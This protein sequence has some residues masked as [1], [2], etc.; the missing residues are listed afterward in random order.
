VDSDVALHGHNASSSTLTYDDNQIAP[1]TSF[2]VRFRSHCLSFLSES[3][4][5]RLVT[6][7]FRD[8][9]E[10]GHMPIVK[11]FR[12]LEFRAKC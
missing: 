4:L 11:P 2:Q 5:S 7:S 10:A 1:N 8:L 9:C 3:V 12:C 6:L